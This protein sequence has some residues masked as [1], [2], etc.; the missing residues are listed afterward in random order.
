MA[1]CLPD[2]IG[3]AWVFCIYSRTKSLSAIPISRLTS[4]LKNLYVPH[5]KGSFVF[6]ASL[7]HLSLVFISLWM[8]SVTQEFG[9]PRI[10][11]DFTG[12]C[13][14]SISLNNVSKAKSLSLT[15]TNISSMDRGTN[16]LRNFFLILKASWSNVHWF[17][18]CLFQFESK[19]N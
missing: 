17:G 14:W 19:I 1:D 18:A 8:L 6:F 15:L 13:Y 3:V 4:C 2:T 16:P 10:L 7:C 9:F 11:K 12:A 5:A